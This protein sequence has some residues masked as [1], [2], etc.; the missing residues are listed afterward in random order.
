MHS[1]YREPEP[2][3]QLVD[4]F[5]VG[6]DCRLPLGASN[7]DDLAVELQLCTGRLGASSQITCPDGISGHCSKFDGSTLIERYDAKT[8]CAIQDL[9]VLRSGIAGMDQHFAESRRGNNDGLSS[10]FEA[11]DQKIEALLGIRYGVFV[12]GSIG[13]LA[14]GSRKSRSAV[15]SKTAII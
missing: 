2:G 8:T 7:R 1:D 5:I 12:R 10:G 3:S 6:V 13:A 14:S 9:E 11:C 15:A 4:V